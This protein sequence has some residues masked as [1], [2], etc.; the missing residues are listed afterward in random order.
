VY[1]L[2]FLG[3]WHI[4]L[5]ETRRVLPP[6]RMTQLPEV[7]HS[8]MYPSLMSKLSY[9]IYKCSLMEMCCVEGIALL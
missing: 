8:N 2:V 6:V 7:L 1:T 4:V 5:A 9:R 3:M